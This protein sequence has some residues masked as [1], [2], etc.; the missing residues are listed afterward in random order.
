MEAIT[1]TMAH[2]DKDKRTRG[3]DGS[4]VCEGSDVI[5]LSMPKA[6]P[7]LARV[8]RILS[9]GSIIVSNGRTVRSVD[10]MSCILQAA[11]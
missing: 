4:W 9:D 1:K 3:M 6:Q 8:L 7:C 11:K 5:C 10:P 2:T